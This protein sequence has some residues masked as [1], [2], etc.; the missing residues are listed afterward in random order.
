[1]PVSENTKPQPARRSVCLTELTGSGSHARVLILK[2]PQEARRR[3]VLVALAFRRQRQEDCCNFED[4]LSYTVSSRPAGAML[5]S[6]ALKGSMRVLYLYTNS[7]DREKSPTSTY[8][9]MRYLRV[10]ASFL[11]QKQLREEMGSFDLHFQVT[12]HRERSG[13]ELKA[14]FQKQGCLLLG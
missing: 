5:V 10:P 11:H 9:S 6:K 7:I 4:S 2:V 1:M 12:V 13:Q 8:A 14:G 3:L